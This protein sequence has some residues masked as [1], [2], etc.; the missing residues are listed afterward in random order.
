MLLI[1]MCLR[2]GQHWLNTGLSAAI[3]IAEKS[4]ASDDALSERVAAS[5][6]PVAH[7]WLQNTSITTT[8]GSSFSAS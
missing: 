4:P 8:T 7:A 5:I 2:R 3:Q 6:A 1:L